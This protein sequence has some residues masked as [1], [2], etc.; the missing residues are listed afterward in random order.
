MGGTKLVRSGRVAALVAE[1]EQRKAIFEEQ[2]ADLEKT[3]PIGTYA[4]F[5]KGQAYELGY[6][7]GRAK[8]ILE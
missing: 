4:T 6:L 3:S 8:L 7:I 5:L 2:A 1:M